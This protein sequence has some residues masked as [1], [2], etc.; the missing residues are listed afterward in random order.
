MSNNQIVSALIKHLQDPDEQV[1]TSSARALGKIGDPEAIPTLVSLLAD[2]EEPVQQAAKQSLAAFGKQAAHSLVSTLTPDSPVCLPALELL[3]PLQDDS[4]VIP[5]IALLGQEKNI[6]Q[7][8]SRVIAGIGEPAIEYLLVHVEDPDSTL[9]IPCARIAAEIGGP[10]VIHSLVEQLSDPDPAFRQ[11]LGDAMR[12]AE[13]LEALIDALHHRDAQIRAESARILGRIGAQESVEPL[14]ALLRDKQDTVKQAAVQALGEMGQNAVAP[15]AECLSGPCLLRGQAAEILKKIQWQPADQA[16]TI[17][18]LAALDDQEALARVVPEQDVLL[19]LLQDLDPRIRS[20]A[21]QQLAHWK[22]SK[23]TGALLKALEMEPLF[24]AMDGGTSGAMTGL[25]KAL[26]AF[27]EER[28]AK[29]LVAQLGKSEPGQ[30]QQIFQAL[31]T[32]GEPAVD[33]LLDALERTN[34]EKL[35]VRTLAKIGSPRAV[36]PL[37]RIMQLDDSKGQEAVKALAAIGKPS[38]LVL[39]AGLHSKQVRTQNRAMDALCQMEDKEA[40]SVLLAALTHPLEAIRKQAGTCLQARSFNPGDTVEQALLEASQG[41]WQ[42][43][44]RKKAFSAKLMAWLADD[45]S[46]RTFAVHALGMLKEKRAVESLLNLLKTDDRTLKEE[47]ITALGRIADERAVAPLAYIMAYEKGWVTAVVQEALVQ[48]GKPAVPAVLEMIDNPELRKTAVRI[49]SR[50]GDPKAFPVLFGLLTGEA[51]E[52]ATAGAAFAAMG[53]AAVEFLGKR[54]P[55]ADTEQVRKIVAVF[56]EMQDPAAAPF[57]ERL[58]AYAHGDIRKQAADVLQRLDRQPANNKEKALYLAALG[59]WQQL[60][61]LGKAG[62]HAIMV[63]LRDP[64]KG[65]RRQAA[66]ALQK[67]DWQGEGEHAAFFCLALEDWKGLVAIGEPA[68]QA[69]LLALEDADADVRRRAADV[70]GE[71]AVSPDSRE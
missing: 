37:Y 56:A 18:F 49:L 62:N 23:V 59:D 27:S 19:N 40:E 65:N 15:L 53:K 22:D 9:R 60:L 21:A 17:R 38:L 20:Y 66:E 6:V 50:I 70:L 14:I 42:G 43:K 46:P 55:E 5:A 4:A 26:S 57:L 54:L 39:E 45:D 29:A 69:L 24:D 7:A 28:V 47:T 67:L 63:S 16:Q 8:A 35:Y 48:I 52:Q 30:Q 2:P 51:E 64:D 61:A 10:R 33:C 58:L 13:P 12:H 71:L 68:Q 25:I 44:A 41:N 34:G 3:G 11:A 31:E 32:I 36:S 1:R